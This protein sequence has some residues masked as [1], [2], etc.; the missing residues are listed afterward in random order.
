LI[1]HQAEC[2]FFIAGE[3][4]SASHELLADCIDSFALFQLGVLSKPDVVEKIDF[5]ASFIFSSFFLS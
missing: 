4:S 3:Y 2:S 5:L 1:I